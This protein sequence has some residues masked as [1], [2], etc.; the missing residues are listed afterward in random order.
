MIFRPRSCRAVSRVAARRRER[1]SDVLLVGVVEE[2]GKEGRAGS[3]HE[4]RCEVNDVG[5]GI[6]RLGVER[7]S[8]AS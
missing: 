6:W 8:A 5:D 3:G 2:V 7:L 4:R 1:G